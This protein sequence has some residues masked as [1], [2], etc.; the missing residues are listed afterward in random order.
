M[1]QK[2]NVFVP[3][4]E[5][6]WVTQHL[7]RKESCSLGATTE[8]VSHHLVPAKESTCNMAS[9]GDFK[10]QAHSY[11]RRWF[12]S[13]SAP[14][15]ICISLLT[16]ILTMLCM[17]YRAY[18]GELMFLTL[19]IVGNHLACGQMTLGGRVNLTSRAQ[20]CTGALM[21]PLDRW[22][23]DGILGTAIICLPGQK[24]ISKTA[25]GKPYTL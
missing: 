23:P 17:N 12:L 14:S 16:C 4:L 11:G 3:W 7:T 10:R 9:L 5:A 21:A 22:H 2:K 18:S 20:P 8:K 1:K 6:N 13:P 19:A 15:C 25:K 24:P